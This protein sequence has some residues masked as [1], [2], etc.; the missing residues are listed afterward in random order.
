M[1]ELGNSIFPVDVTKTFFN[2]E[3][4][5][6]INYRV[7]LLSGLSLINILKILRIKYVAHIGNL[8]LNIYQVQIDKSELYLKFHRRT[9]WKGATVLAKSKFV[10]N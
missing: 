2:F 7:L 9:H 4:R 8:D 5:I 6:L 1:A 3:G 10:Y